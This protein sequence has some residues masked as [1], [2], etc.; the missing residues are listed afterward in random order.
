MYSSNWSGGGGGYGE[1]GLFALYVKISVGLGNLYVKY[2]GNID[3]APVSL[4]IP[5][6]VNLCH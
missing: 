4:K 2:I 6:V 3:I 1:E 5:I